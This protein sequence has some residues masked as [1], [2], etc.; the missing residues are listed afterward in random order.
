MDPRLNP[1]A[2]GAGTRPPE[3]AGREQILHDAQIALA[4]VRA[5]R[6]AKGQ[7]L[8][9]LR[10]VGKTVL[11][12]RIEEIAEDE[13][14]RTVFIEAPEN[15]RLPE[16]LVPPLRRVLVK[17]DRGERLQ[18][19][20]RAAL[21][22][23]RSFASAFKVSVGGL[24]IGVEGEPGSADSGDLSAD[25]PEL[26]LAVAA[27]AKESD[28]AVALIIDEVQYL[29]SEDLGALIVAIHKVT[30][31]GLP[32]ILFGAGLPQLA[33]LAGD[34]KSY[35]E[36]LFDYPAV[37]AL[38]PADAVDALREPARRERVDYDDE[39]LGVIVA[40][41]QG[42]PYFLQEWGKHA[43]NVAAASPIA[44][45]DA[46]EATERAIRQLDEGFFR[47]RLDRLTP[48]EKQ[49]MGAMAR[50][51]PGPHRSGDIARLM[52]ES[53]SAVAP[54]RQG[55]IRKGM[56][57]SPAH[58]DTSFTVPMFDEFLRRHVP[59]STGTGRTGTPRRKPAKGE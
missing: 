11:L 27:A 55:L 42:Y 58:G 31:R 34:T 7:L 44:V 15:R 5:G 40:T 22:T 4:R 50:L 19:Q 52:G 8:L 43:W 46:H 29:S 32:L 20:A 37:G 33:A 2:P 54:L 23:L 16:L 49:Y 18:G 47:V 9:G 39:A 10:G 25:L 36:R 26:L 24:E 56:I 41:T 21:R 53:V 14:Y 38:S 12:N 28:S 35:A 13:G 59:A 48:R 1:Y 51:G 45:G 3:L 30:Q 17:L 57:F 6:H